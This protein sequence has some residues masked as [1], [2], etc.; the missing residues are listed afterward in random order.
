MSVEYK[1]KD[2]ESKWQKRWFKDLFY[3]SEDF[4]EGIGKVFRVVRFLI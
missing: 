4:A 1:P 3:E 2:F